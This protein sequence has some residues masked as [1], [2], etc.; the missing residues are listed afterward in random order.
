MIF[1]LIVFYLYTLDIFSDFAIYL[2]SFPVVY[3][4][5]LPEYTRIDR[6]YFIM[7]DNVEEVSGIITKKRN[8]I[9]WNLVSNVKMKKGVFGTM[10]D[11]GD[12]VIGTMSNKGNIVMRGINS[13]ENVLKKLEEKIGKK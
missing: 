2:L 12:I 3:L 13:P 5:L 7:E 11:Y 10:L 9:P 1:A 4:F 8:I 6:K